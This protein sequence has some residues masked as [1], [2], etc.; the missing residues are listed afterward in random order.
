MFING[1]LPH[2]NT[3]YFVK[4]REPVDVGPDTPGASCYRIYWPDGPHGSACAED[5]Y[6]V[7]EDQELAGLDDDAM[8]LV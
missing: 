6:H 3:R 4:C 5:A 7:D 1:M 8:D 2:G